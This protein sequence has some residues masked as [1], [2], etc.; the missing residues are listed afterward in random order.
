MIA[1]REVALRE[2]L[3]DALSQ[4]E[5]QLDDARKMP[6]MPTRSLQISMLLSAKVQILHSFTLL[7]QKKGS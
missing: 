6:D 2:E 3:R 1:I 5:S 7:Q 4:V